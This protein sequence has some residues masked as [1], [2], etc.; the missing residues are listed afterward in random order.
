MGQHPTD[1]PGRQGLAGTRRAHPRRVLVRP[2]LV[3]ESHLNDDDN[4]TDFAGLYDT[5]LLPD[6]IEKANSRWELYLLYLDRDP[7][8]W[9]I[10]AAGDEERYTAGT[11]FYTN[12][13]PWDFDVEADY[14]FGDYSDGDIAAWS[15]A[16]EAGH[17]FES[18]LSPRLFVGL[19]VASGDR[20]PGD[21]DLNTFNQL[22]P[23][24]HAYLGY[25]DVIGRQ[26]IIDA[27]P[28]IELTL[29]QEKQYAKKLTLRADYHVFWRQS[30]DD[31]LYNAGG[32]VQRAPGGSD[33]RFVGS[34]IDLMLT[35]QIERHTQAYFGYSHFLRRRLHRGD[36]PERGY[37]LR[38]CGGA[39]HVL[40]EAPEPETS[41]HAAESAG[42]AERRREGD[43]GF[44][45]HQVVADCDVIAPPRRAVCR[46]GSSTTSTDSKRPCVALNKSAEVPSTT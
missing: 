10:E 18:D 35:W 31:A 36:R 24:G 33:E 45:L 4:N 9:P 25:I 43:G 39:I 14:Q 42:R 34:E 1:F 44:T 22:F 23:L 29:A 16:T 2:I 30:G 41:A 13:K 40:E 38:L 26:N 19:D 27:H 12:P 21:G 3:E 5:I 20:D 28:G 32:G 7:A 8:S 17:T 15:V 11:R 46:R 37:R 6:L